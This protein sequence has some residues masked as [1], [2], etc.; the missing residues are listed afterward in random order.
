[1]RYVHARLRTGRF[2]RRL[3]SLSRAPGRADNRA[4]ALLGENTPGA[5]LLEYRLESGSSRAR[6]Y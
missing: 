1:M 6:P 4:E 3:A 2:A 5:S